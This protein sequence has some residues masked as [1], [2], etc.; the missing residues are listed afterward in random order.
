MRPPLIF[1][2][3]WGTTGAVWEPVLEILGQCGPISIFSWDQW[4]QED[5]SPKKH[6]E[7]ATQAALLVGWSLGG[8][9]ALQAAFSVPERVAGLCLIST[10]ARMLEDRDYVGVPEKVL[11]AMQ[12]QF[13]R[14][15]RGV[16]ENFA[17][18]CFYPEKKPDLSRSFIEM[19][20][21]FP[22]GIMNRGL[23]FLKETD[24]RHRLSHIEGPV[25]L[26]HGI[27]DAIIP[28]EQ[29][30]YLEALLNNA[31]LAISCGGHGLP[32]THASWLTRQIHDFYAQL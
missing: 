14:N 25:L 29:G 7:S 4:F 23:R 30:R 24:L 32:F 13:K 26:L 15:P 18:N 31:T 17:E 28:V 12:V 27:K 1:I 3:G 11:K 20:Q 5:N 21:S 6:L 10:T 19:A 2:S 22:H 8:L 9:L 16:M